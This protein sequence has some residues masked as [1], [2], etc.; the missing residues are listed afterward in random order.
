MS[1]QTSGNGEGQKQIYV[2]LTGLQLLIRLDWPFHRSTSGADF[3]VL[4]GDVRLANSEA[5]HAPVAVNLSVTVREVLPSLEPKEVEAPVVNSLRKEVD[6]RQLEF[7][8]SGKVVPVQFS[9]R[10]WDFKRSKWVFGK[11]T[12]AEISQLL[13][14]KVFWS[15]RLTQGPAW[16][17]DPTEALYVG[18][19]PEHIVE[20]AR[21]LEKQELITL[22]G[23]M[24]SAAL[25]LMGQAEKIEGD[26]KAALEEL[27][28]KH[29]FERG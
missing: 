3:F 8:K 11:A 14:R 25:S 18:T 10:H 1:A 15:G 6:R 12:D 19:T 26:A 5:L 23:E 24:A 28:K 21:E 29:A 16:V 17:G 7:L 2:T 22:T 13:A 27:E 9:S 20:L 4:H